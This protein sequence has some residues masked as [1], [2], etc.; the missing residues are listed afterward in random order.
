ML[1]RLD[2][3]NIF[4]KEEVGFDSPATGIV[5]LLAAA[6]AIKKALKSR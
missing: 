2:A 5:T 3:L 4:D 6:N 1:A